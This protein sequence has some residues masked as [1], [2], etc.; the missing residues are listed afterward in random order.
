MYTVPPS[1]CSLTID[2][3]GEWVNRMQ[4]GTKVTNTASRGLMSLAHCTMSAYSAGASSTSQLV[5]ARGADFACVLLG[6][7]V[8]C[9]M[10]SV[11][12]FWKMFGGN[13]LLRVV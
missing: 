13:W 1:T 10:V 7:W 11:L 3:R 2:V 4:S 9:R 5:V 8:V 6:A 12:F